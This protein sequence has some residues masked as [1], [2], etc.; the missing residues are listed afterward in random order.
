MGT[1]L[2]PEGIGPNDVM[3]DLMN[4]MGWKVKEVDIESWV[5]DYSHRY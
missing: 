4:E 3:F 5:R 2:T 1:G